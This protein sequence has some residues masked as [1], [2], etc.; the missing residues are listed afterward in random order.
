MMLFLSGPLPDWRGYP[1]TGSGASAHMVNNLCH[2]LKPVLTMSRFKTVYENLPAPVPAAIEI[3]RHILVSPCSLYEAPLSAPVVERLQW[4]KPSLEDENESY[5]YFNNMYKVDEHCLD[6][7]G[8]CE[9]FCRVTVWKMR[10]EP[11][12]VVPA[13][14]KLALILKL[15]G[16]LARDQAL[17]LNED[18]T[19]LSGQ[20]SWKYFDLQ[21]LVTPGIDTRPWFNSASEAAVHRLAQTP[22]LSERRR[23]GDEGSDYWAGFSSRSDESSLTSGSDGRRD[24]GRDTIPID[25]ILVARIRNTPLYRSKAPSVSSTTN[26]DQHDPALHEAPGTPARGTGPVDLRSRISRTPLYKRAPSVDESPPELAQSTTKT[27]ADLHRLLDAARI[28]NLPPP[29]APLDSR[30]HPQTTLHPPETSSHQPLHSSRPASSSTQK[31]IQDK[32]VDSLRATFHLYRL[33]HENSGPSEASE[34]SRL[35]SGESFIALA[36]RVVL[37]ETSSRHRP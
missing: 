24:D 26:S 22:R 31:E 1:H 4:I 34:P 7:N 17:N 25:P 35:S 14:E 32:L 18:R 9:I 15:E 6:S 37:Q 28:V 33:C 21:D 19:A 10:N 13:K 12:E 2:I 29:P 36:H 3:I 23:S 8:L 5:L 27:D 11:D 16:D 20:I 30:S